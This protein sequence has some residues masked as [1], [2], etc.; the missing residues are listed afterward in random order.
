MTRCSV[1]LS[2]PAHIEA[3]AAAAAAHASP[4]WA[5]DKQVRVPSWNNTQ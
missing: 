4:S 3:A 5:A 1:K 2:S